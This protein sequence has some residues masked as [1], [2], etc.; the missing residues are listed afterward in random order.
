MSG[1][2]SKSKNK[3]LLIGGSGTLGS[4]IKKSN[5]FKNISSPTKENLNLLNKIQIK[6]YLD[7][8]FNTIINCAGYPRIRNC[9]MNK[10]K[11][12]NLNVKTTKNLVDEMIV[13]EKKN[14]EKIKLIQISSDAVYSSLKGN[15]KEIDKCKPKSYYG[16]CKLQSEKIVKKLSNYLIIRTR[17]FNKK[18]IKYKD[19]AVDIY[20]SML[21]VEK[22]VKYIFLLE[23]KRIKGIINVGKKSESD[24]NNIKRYNKNIKKTSRKS[25]SKNSLVFITK[26]ASMNLKKLNKI[27][28]KHV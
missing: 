3:I 18:K 28:S 19:A 11:S 16:F 27:M 10:K 24:F 7:K 9:E 21:E 13:Q 4:A 22:L 17:F 12:F 6:K 8:K 25:I 1:D 5:L 2:F 14:M 20:S 23:K 15:Y 26:D